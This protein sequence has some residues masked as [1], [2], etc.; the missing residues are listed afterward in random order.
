MK[1]YGQ[2]CSVAKALDVIGDRWTMLILREL[3]VRGP[4]RYTDLALG[5]PGIA[6]NL[7]SDRLR[8]LEDEGLVARQVAPPPVAATLLDLTE[9]GRATEPILAALA[10]W[11]IGYVADAPGP[12]DEFRPYWFPSSVSAF[13]RDRA[14]GTPPATVQLVTPIG[15]WVIE[16]SEDRTA[17]SE[18]NVDAPDLI[19]DGHP[20]LILRYL[21][22]SCTLDEALK[23]G[24]SVSG[25]RSLL[26]TFPLLPT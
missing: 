3:L 17:V 4:C 15:S 19:V 23:D 5:L 22:G 24:L 1:T 18:G 20:Q 12:E 8:M 2:F 16:V 6:S 13:L 11:G 9:R 14:P 25:D 7:L 10:R 26:G 21:S